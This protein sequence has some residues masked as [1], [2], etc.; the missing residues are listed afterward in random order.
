[1]SEIKQIILIHPKKFV[2]KSFEAFAKQ[3]GFA[4]YTIESPVEFAYLVD[5]LCPQLLLVHEDL[6]VNQGEAYFIEIAGVSFSGFKQVLIRSQKSSREAKI[7]DKFPLF[8]DEPYDLGEL[9]KIL[10]SLLAEHH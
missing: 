10:A 5:E 9:D 3:M 2:C 6:L 7:S 8:L 1:V 4:V